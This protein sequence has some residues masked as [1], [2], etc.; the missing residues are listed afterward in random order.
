MAD[1]NN[2][3]SKNLETFP[4][5]EDLLKAGAQFGH[6]TKRRNPAFSPYIY[7]QRKG[8]H[9]ID[10][11][12]TIPALERAVDFLAKVLS[13][14]G[15]VLLVGTKKQAAP[16]VKEV[17]EKYGVYYINGKWPPG[18]LT[19]FRVLNQS[20]SKLANLRELY[21]KKKYVYTKKE[22]LSIKRKI[23]ALSKRFEGVLFMDKL[24]DVMIITDI[25]Y[26]KIALKEARTMGIP[27]IAL[28][29]SNADPRLVDYPIP[30]NDDAIKSIRLF[31]N[32]FSEVFSK[33]GTDKLLIMRERFEKQLSLLEKNIDAAHA[34]KEAAHKQ[35]V[36]T[37]ADKTKEKRRVVRVSAYKPISVLA[38][39][40]GIE[41]KLRAAGITSVEMLKTKDLAELKAIKGIGE[42]SA[43][44][45]ISI[46][47][48]YEQDG[49][50][51]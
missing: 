25:V 33:Y 29:D 14:K 48:K 39:G 34:T 7:K 6:S 38:L 49:N 10:I 3:V 18:L 8:I 2:V 44:K 43:E 17:G 47:K 41:N 22:L 1:S 32:V 4:T 51:S 12:Q 36:V 9:I 24:P 26:E 28:V 15:R 35:E 13:N 46:V 20:I 11:R 50:R 5:L 40:E 42:K 21:I 19:N 30:A 45:I 37:A 31:F 16:I 23:D 27:V